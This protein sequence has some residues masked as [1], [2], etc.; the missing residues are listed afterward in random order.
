[1]FPPFVRLTINN[2]KI[3][4]MKRLVIILLALCSIVP[5][6]SQKTIESLFD[7]YAKKDNYTTININGLLLRS[8]S[9][10]EAMKNVSGIRVIASTERSSKSLYNDVMKH[11]D[12]SRYEE[13]VTVKEQ[14]ND[15]HILVNQEGDFFKEVLILVGGD[16]DVLVQIKGNIPIDDIDKITGNNGYIPSASLN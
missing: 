14:D 3:I 9:N 10:D 2:F 1:M 6:F 12:K 13:F 7:N 5:A 8:F 4:V 16:E 11:L 15:V